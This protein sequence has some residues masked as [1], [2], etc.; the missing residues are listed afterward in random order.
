M[1]DIT[2]TAILLMS[3][4]CLDGSPQS[5]D[6]CSDGRPPSVVEMAVLVSSCDPIR[7]EECAARI[8][9]VVEVRKDG[10]VIL[11]VPASAIGADVAARL[12]QA[13]VPLWSLPK[14]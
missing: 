5:V 10:A 3:S 11:S 6:G 2:T 7:S 14:P 4:L 13:T 8:S 1:T 9:T 12:W